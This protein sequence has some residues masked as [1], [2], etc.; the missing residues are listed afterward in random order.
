MCNIDLLNGFKYLSKSCLPIQHCSVFF[1]F[2]FFFLLD[3]HKGAN[4]EACSLQPALQSVQ[5][6]SRP[7]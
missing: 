7:A 3:L 5:A 2:F 1:L 4:A 6:W